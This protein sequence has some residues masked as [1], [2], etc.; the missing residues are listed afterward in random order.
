MVTELSIV[1]VLKVEEEN[2]AMSIVPKKNDPTSVTNY[3][4]DADYISSNGTDT[5]QAHLARWIPSE[6]NPKFDLESGGFPNVWK[7]T[8]G[9]YLTIDLGQPRTLSKLRIRGGYH[10]GDICVPD[11]IEVRIAKVQEGLHVTETTV[12]SVADPNDV[13]PQ[14]LNFPPVFGQFVQL[15]P[16]RKNGEPACFALDILGKGGKKLPTDFC[17]DK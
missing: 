10:Y 16:A 13:K 14:E 6:I 15:K 5:Y 12:L 11:T 7:A 4:D 9:S 2:S 1:D 17:E 8:P 3:L